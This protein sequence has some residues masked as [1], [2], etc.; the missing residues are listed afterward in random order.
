[1]HCAWQNTV[2]KYKR[3]NWTEST[4]AK[5]SGTVIIDNNNNNNKLY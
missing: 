4:F 5:T 1:M 2:R 3:G